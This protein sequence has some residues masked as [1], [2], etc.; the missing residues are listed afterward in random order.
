MFADD[1]KVFREIGSIE[2]KYTLQKYLNELQEWSN[3]RFLRFHRDKYKVMTISRKM[4]RDKR[5][6]TELVSDLRDLTY[7]ERLRKSLV[8]RRL[9]GDMIE[10]YETVSG[11]YDEQ[12]M[13]DVVI[14]TEEGQINIRRIA[15]SC[16]KISTRSG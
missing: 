3:K 4:K 2:D 6:Y 10:M 16:Q 15:I 14:K 8:Y 12:V 1:T 11:V 13:P 7:T 5:K 9:R